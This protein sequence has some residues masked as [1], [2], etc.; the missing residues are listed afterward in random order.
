[1][2][3]SF[4]SVVAPVTI[5]IQA[6]MSILLQLLLLLADVVLPVCLVFPD[7]GGESW[8]VVGRM[9]RPGQYG[10]ES[11]QVARYNT[12]QH[13]KSHEVCLKGERLGTWRPLFTGLR[14]WRC[15]WDS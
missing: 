8:Q 2:P 13:F 12:S 7:G 6:P 11:P 3:C 10:F 9:P 14:R 5:H 15:L 4:K 1:M